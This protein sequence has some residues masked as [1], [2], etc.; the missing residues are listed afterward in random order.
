MHADTQST[1]AFYAGAQG[2]MVARLLRARLTRLWPSARGLSLLGIGYAAPY[3]RP[4]LGQ[5][6]ERVVALTQAQ[7]GVARW[8]LGEPGLSCTAEEDALP[9]PDLCFDRVLLVH[10]LESAENASRLLRES[11]RVLKDDG[12]LLVVAPNRRG[13]WAYADAT[14]FGQG[15]PYSK[16]Q[17][18]RLLEAS[19]FRV[20]RRDAALF[21]PPVRLRAFLRSAAAWER[22]GRVLAP[23]FAGVTL[24]EAEKDIYAAIPAGAV[25]RRR[26]VIAEAA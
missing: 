20:A 25:A 12:R 21:V 6:A 19:L 22:A 9:F 7:C 10:G 5:G 14:P 23:Q 24:T 16:G 15:Q 26:L 3:L 17:V 11:W 2:A 1:A 18:T 8:P 13:W 4:Y